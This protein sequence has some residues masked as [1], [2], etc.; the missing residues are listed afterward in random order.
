VPTWEERQADE[1]QVRRRWDRQGVLDGCGPV[2]EAMVRVVD[3][4]PNLDRPRAEALEAAYWSTREAAEAAGVVEA[5]ERAFAYT[6]AFPDHPGDLYAI[7]PWSR[8]AFSYVGLLAREQAWALGAG[9]IGI[10]PLE[11]TAMGAVLALSVEL[12]GRQGWYHPVSE[13]LAGWLARPWRQALGSAV[14]G[15]GVTA[16]GGG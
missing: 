16:D 1:A 6:A 4:I 13:E 8:V 11:R 10:V 5:W 7:D 15:Q 14:T 12:A 9:E 3:A 2:G